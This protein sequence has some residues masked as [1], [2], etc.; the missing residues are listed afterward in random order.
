[1]KYLNLLGTKRD[2]TKDVQ[3]VKIFSE[4]IEKKLSFS[5]IPNDSKLDN[6]TFEELQDLNKILGL[7][8]FIL[9]KYEEK[10]ETLLI[11]QN[12]VSII[13]DYAHSIED[14]DDEISELIISAED[15]I[16]KVKETHSH[17]YEKSD[18]VGS[19]S[20]TLPDDSKSSSINLTNF[21]TEINLLEY[22]QNSQE[23][24]AQVI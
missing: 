8:D 12:F 15:S 7:T 17:I 18:L 9:C 19:L 20:P 22:Q 24:N 6:L 13:N 5:K 23:E 1:M 14:V 4:K 11:L 2:F 21:T 10:K 16:N 3:L